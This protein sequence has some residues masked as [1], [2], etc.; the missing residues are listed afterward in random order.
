MLSVNYCSRVEGS[1]LKILLQR[2]RNLKCLMMQQTNLKDE[3][4]MAAEWDK[5]TALQVAYTC[6]YSLVKMAA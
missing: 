2:C 4:V 6:S 3:H 5:A 1:S